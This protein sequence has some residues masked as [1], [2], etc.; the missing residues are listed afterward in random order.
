MNDDVRTSDTLITVVVVDD[1]VVVREGTRQLLDRED[2]IEVVGEASTVAEAV[3][4]A[5]RLLPTVM[6]VDVELPD[7]SGVEVVREVVAAGLAV[8]CLMLS[9]HDDLIF[10]AEAL[11]AGAAGYLL[12]TA[13]AVELIATVRAVSLGTVVID[14]SLSRRLAGRLRHPELNA[15]ALTFRELDIVR[16]LVR[17]RSNKEIALE[18]DIGLRTVET[19]VS[20]VLAK[21]GV[22]SR[23]EATLYAIKHHLVSS[24]SSE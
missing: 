9:A 13:S 6:V 14:E 15:P 18:L 3:A 17:G 19:Y 22:R 5:Q 2:G 21:L 4:L 23:T 16:A 10:I 8:R 12:K 1:H 20:N 11:A 24:G 7:Q